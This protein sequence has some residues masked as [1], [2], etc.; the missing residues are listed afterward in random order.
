MN[1]AVSRKIPRKTPRRRCV[2]PNLASDYPQLATLGGDRDLL[3]PPEPRRDDLTR[4][5]RFDVP[6]LAAGGD[7]TVALDVNEQAL[8]RLTCTKALVVV[9]RATHLFE[10]PGAL[11]D[12][13]DHAAAWFDRHCGRPAHLQHNEGLGVRQ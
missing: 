1:A 5:L 3:T 4:E 10:E 12:V 2:P 13:C 11:D 8:G 7:D 9:P 6:L